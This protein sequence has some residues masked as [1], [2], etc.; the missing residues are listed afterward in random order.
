MGD[1]VSSDNMWIFGMSLNIFGSVMV[2]FGTNLMKSAHNL[3]EESEGQEQSNGKRETNSHKNLSEKVGHDSSKNIFNSRNVWFLG[4]SIF[5]VGSLV[6]FSSFAFAAQ[7]LLAALG[8]VQF[9]SNVFFAKFVLGEVLTV[10]IIVATAI[11]VFGLVM[12]ILFSNHASEAYTSEDLMALYTP[13]YFLFLIFMAVLLISTH[14][15]YSIYTYNE[16]NGSPLPGSGIVRPAAYSIV[17]A[18]VGT[19]S[20]LQSKCFAELVKASVNGNNQFDHFFVY[21]IVVGFLC[22]LS[23]WLYRMNAALK[24]FDG[25]IIIPLLQVFWT[26]SAILQGGVYFQEF[27]K[28]TTRQTLFFLLGVAIVFFGVYL[29][30]P[31]PRE[32]GDADLLP[33]DSE[34]SLVGAALDSGSL[35]SS[36]HSSPSSHN[37]PRHQRFTNSGLSVSKH[38]QQSAFMESTHSLV[39]LTFLPVVVVERRAH[40]VAAMSLKLGDIEASTKT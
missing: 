30:T 22:G 40:A 5:V 27:S 9:V 28:F 25:L 19:Q 10:R 16:E 8:T 11:I 29:L 34:K 31:N 36:Q 15:L 12:A 26:T 37:R 32:K 3:F 21:A 33:S 2:N 38:D 7:S 13:G 35:W 20:V 4:M 24:M 39:S 17:S 23:F 1:F 18:V 14:I 6:N